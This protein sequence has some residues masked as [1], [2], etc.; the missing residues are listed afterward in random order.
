MIPYCNHTHRRPLASH[1]GGFTLIELLVVIAI[2]GVL[3]ALALPAVQRA[4]ES[5]RRTECVNN[6]RQ[7][8]LAIHTF[9]DAKENLP[10]SGRPTA[11]S[12]VRYGVFTQLLPYLDQ[13]TLYN[14]YDATV[15]WSHANNTPVTGVAMETYQCPSAPR[16]N[17][18]LD[19]NPDNF[20]GTVTTWQGIVSVGDYAASLGVDPRLETF[21]AGLTPPLVVVGSDSV[22]TSGSTITNG[23]LPKNSALQFGDITDGLSNTIAI[24]ESGGR[25]FVYRNKVQVSSNLMTAHTNAGGWCRPA[26]DILFAGSSK[27]GATIPGAFLNRANGYNHAAEAYSTTGFPAPYGTEGSSQPYGFHTAGLNVLFGDN[28]VKFLSQDTAI[29]I[30]AALVTRNAGADEATLDPNLF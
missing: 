25:P 1:R 24:W 23:M 12:T 15:N 29:Q 28:S 7:I 3:A 2:I 19:H 5:A 14:K 17:N 27:D 10:S 18:T 9:Y 30:V 21:A 22:T 6:L 13:E 26:S 4:R 11:A 8:G 16:H 20:N